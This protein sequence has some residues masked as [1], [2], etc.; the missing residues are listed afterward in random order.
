ME[1]KISLCDHNQL[2]F[3]QHKSTA[4]A[5]GFSGTC[6]TIHSYGVAS[7]TLLPEKS[8]NKQV[9]PATSTVGTLNTVCLDQI[10][11]TFNFQTGNLRHIHMVCFKV[12]LL[13]NGFE[14]GGDSAGSLALT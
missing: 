6:S 10:T 13:G 5:V 1:E 14:G 11:S 9:G 8:K 12:W 4:V 3:N 7:A 2:H